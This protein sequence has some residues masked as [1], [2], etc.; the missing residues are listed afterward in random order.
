MNDFILTQDLRPAVVKGIEM[1]HGF[2]AQ[3]NAALDRFLES[4]GLL[5]R[6]DKTFGRDVRLH[7]KPRRDV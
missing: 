5:T 7:R 3:V 1:P 2:H 4:R 6:D